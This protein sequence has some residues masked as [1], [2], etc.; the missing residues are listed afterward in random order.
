MGSIKT[1]CRPA[2]PLSQKMERAPAIG[3]K[4]RGPGAKPLV[5]FPPFLTGEM[6]AAGRH[7]PGAL[8]PEAGNSPDHP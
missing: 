8:R 2:A 5:F 7:P 1:H 3:L 6:E 4:N